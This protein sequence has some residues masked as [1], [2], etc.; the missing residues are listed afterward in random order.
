[1]SD[2]CSPGGGLS[3]DAVSLASRIVA[4]ADVYDALSQ[5]RGY[6]QAWPP[7]KVL[8]TIRQGRG[9]QFDPDV[10]DAFFRILPQIEEV[11]RRFAEPA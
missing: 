10:V 2:C 1:M 11:R 9:S 8:E 7:E 3:G 5:A 6:K 4:L